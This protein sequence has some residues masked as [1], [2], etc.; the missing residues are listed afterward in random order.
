MRTEQTFAPEVGEIRAARRFVAS[1]APEGIRDEVTLV[2]SELV[3]NAIE[4]ART[5]VTVRVEVTGDII[6]VEVADS[7]AIVPT[8]TELV[9]DGAHGRGLHLVDALSKRWGVESNEHGKLV[10]FE[11][12][13]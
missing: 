6:R 7:S 12:Y 4:H 11:I 13:P 1:Y 8:I 9:R 2:A 3:T 10:W 5:P